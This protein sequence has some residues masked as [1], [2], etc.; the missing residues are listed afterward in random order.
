M[1]SSTKQRI[2]P[3]FA[4]ALVHRDDLAGY[5]RDPTATCAA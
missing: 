5:F 4:P 3:A 1:A 2:T